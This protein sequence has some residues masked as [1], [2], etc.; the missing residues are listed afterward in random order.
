M[1]NR[2]KLPRFESQES[3]WEESGLFAA[4]D[5]RYDALIDYLKLSPSYQL[6]CE[7]A[8]KGKKALP[9]NA[10]KD[11]QQIVKTYEDFGDVWRIPESRWWD[12]RGKALFGIKAAKAQTFAVGYSDEAT[13]INSST[14]TQSRNTW[15]D[16]GKPECL[17]LAIPTNQTKQMALKQINAIVRAGNFVCTKPKLIRPKYEL[18]RSKLREPTIKLGTIA[19]KMYQNGYP[20]WL[21]G[22]RLELSPAHHIKLD[23]KGNPDPGELNLADKKIRLQILASKLVA[24]AELIAENAAR[25][26]Y[27][28]DAPCRY[29]MKFKSATRKVGRPSKSK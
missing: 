13:L 1:T 18:I 23:D 11:W 25:G 3:H 14:A 26:L 24:K 19:L 2:Q 27:P 10:P 28:T 9:A 5:W 7:W 15:Q 12:S 8:R 22:T 21:I 16:M 6:V 17:V 20:L 29:A 4:S